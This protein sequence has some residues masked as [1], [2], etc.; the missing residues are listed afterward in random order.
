MTFKEIQ[1]KLNS[2]VNESNAVSNG[3]SIKGY[4][5]VF[6]QPTLQGIKTHTKFVGGSC[7]KDALKN[8]RKEMECVECY[9][10]ISI[11]SPTEVRG[12]LTY[13]VYNNTHIL[14]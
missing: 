4:E 2:K 5:I 11:D 7:P 13:K 10:V 8:F 6:E 1:S 9:N 14:R 3:K 12:I